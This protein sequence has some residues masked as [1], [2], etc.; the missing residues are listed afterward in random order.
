MRN[1]RFPSL[2]HHRRSEDALKLLD[3]LLRGY[4]RR[5]TPHNNQGERMLSEHMRNPA[6][7]LTQTRALTKNEKKMRI[8]DV[9][10]SIG[11]A[12]NVS[13]ELYVASLGSIN[14][15][16]MVNSDKKNRW[17]RELNVFPIGLRDGLLFTP[18]V[19]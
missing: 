18:K 13:L 11:V 10:R 3:S 1:K 17:E 7:I 6:L 4:D 5:S 19:D 14:T 8:A 2:S 16:N 9:L 12:T 15:E